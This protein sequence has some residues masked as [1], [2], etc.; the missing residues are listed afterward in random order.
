VIPCKAGSETI[1]ARLEGRVTLHA[2]ETVRLAWAPESIHLFDQDSGKRH[3]SE[4]PQARI[5]K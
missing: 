2:G 1:A 5:S 3:D 4:L